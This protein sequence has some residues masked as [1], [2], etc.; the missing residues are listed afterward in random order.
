MRKMQRYVYIFVSVV[1]VA[2]QS[3]RDYLYSPPEFPLEKE[4]R[5]ELLSDELYFNTVSDMWEYGDYLLVCAYNKKNNKFLHLYDKHSG[6]YVGSYLSRGRGPGEIFFGHKNTSFN[7]GVISFF[8]VMSG[9]VV[10]FSVDSMASGRA[11]IDEKKLPMSLGTVYVGKVKDGYVCVVSK[12]PYQESVPGESRFELR[13]EAFNIIDKSDFAPT[14]TPE[15][16]FAMIVHSSYA[17][18][19]DLTR[20]CIVSAQGAIIETYTVDSTLRSNVV[21]YF[22]EP[23]FEIIYGTYDFNERTILGFNDVFATNDRL[24]TVY[25]GEVNPFK[26]NGDRLVDTRI[27]VFDW[28]GNPLELVD[29]DYSI[30]TICYSESENTIYAAVTDRDGIV[31]LAKLAL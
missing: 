26:N 2:L 25:D 8:D 22:Y 11:N 30:E 1:I 14:L 23:D 13:D 12:N 28:E 6:S 17:V 18:S 27:A 7:D 10:D 4:S 20:F 9:S 16:M 19:P 3:C 21:K 5:F 29:T 31:Y 24:F 15:Q